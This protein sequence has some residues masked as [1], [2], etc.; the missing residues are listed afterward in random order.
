[1]PSGRYRPHRGGSKQSLQ[2]TAGQF[3]ERKM[4]A[5]LFPVL[6]VFVI[7]LL[8]AGPFVTIWSINT[9]WDV[10]NP[11]DFTHWFAAAV[12]EFA[13]TGGVGLFGRFR[14]RG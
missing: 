3:K 7:V 5:T 14:S 11:Y 4:K 2:G 6:L 8:T 13:L 9:L 1:M 12:L 10:S